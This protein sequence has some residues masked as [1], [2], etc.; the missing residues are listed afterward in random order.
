MAMAKH[1]IDVAAAV[2]SPSVRGAC[3]SAK[4]PPDVGF[5]AESLKE[6]AAYG[7]RARTS[8]CIWKM[9]MRGVRR[10]FFG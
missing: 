2:G 9:T 6:V 7:E 1:W 4:N 8:W 10:L 3:S 5:A